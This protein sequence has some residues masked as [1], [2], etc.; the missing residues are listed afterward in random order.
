MTG[1]VIVG[2]ERHQNQWVP[3]GTTL[4]QVHG[5]L[6]T[7][8]ETDLSTREQKVRI[9]K[10][11]EWVWV[12][13]AVIWHAQREAGYIEVSDSGLERTLVLHDDYGHWF[14]YQVVRPHLTE[15]RQLCQ[16]TYMGQVRDP[17][18]PAS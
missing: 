6:I 5:D 17:K 3:D 11:D 15:S 13:D 8:L 7:Q 10:A 9:L 12:S 18:V 16:Q 4:H 2:G 14:T 1:H